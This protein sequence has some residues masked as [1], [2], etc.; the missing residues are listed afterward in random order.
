MILTYSKCPKKRW[1]IPNPWAWMCKMIKIWRGRLEFLIKFSSAI[2]TGPGS[3]WQDWGNWE[4]ESSRIYKFECHSRKCEQ[5]NWIRIESFYDLLPKAEHSEWAAE[6]I[7]SLQPAFQWFTRGNKRVR[8]AVE[9]GW[10]GK[11]GPRKWKEGRSEIKFGLQEF[12]PWLGEKV[13]GFQQ[14]ARRHWSWSRLGKSAFQAISLV[15]HGQWRGRN[16][17]HKGCCRSFAQRI[18]TG[19]RVQQ[20]IVTQFFSN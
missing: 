19:Q 10:Y 17:S 4:W 7:R 16:A 18:S 6:A 15:Q 2:K 14:A 1:S 12:H 9:H 13:Q 8:N 20:R 3:G 11:R 5:L